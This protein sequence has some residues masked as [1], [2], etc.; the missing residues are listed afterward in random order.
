MLQTLLI[1]A[2]YSAVPL[3]TVEKHFHLNTSLVFTKLIGENVQISH[4]PMTNLSLKETENI[5]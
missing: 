2:D 5:K 4:P 3:E 1:P